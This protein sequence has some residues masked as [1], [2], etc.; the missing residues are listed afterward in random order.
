MEREIKEVMLGGSK[1][2]SKRW[3]RGRAKPEPQQLHSDIGLQN[4][5]EDCGNKRKERR[6]QANKRHKK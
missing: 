4:F 3:R 2:E 6:D 5:A 1:D